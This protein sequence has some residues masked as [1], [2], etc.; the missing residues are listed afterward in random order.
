[1]IGMIVCTRVTNLSPLV[2]VLIERNTMIVAGAT[3][4]IRIK[5]IG[6]CGSWRERKDSNVSWKQTD[7]DFAGEW[8][9]LLGQTGRQVI[10]GTRNCLSDRASRGVDGN[11]PGAFHP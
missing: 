3:F 1:L 7:S 11:F 5:L 10:A 4:E 6:D 9:D 2:K 8:V